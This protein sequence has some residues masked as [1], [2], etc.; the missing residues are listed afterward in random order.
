MTEKWMVMQSFALGVNTSKNSVY[1]SFSD[2][3][4]MNRYWNPY[5][6]NGDPVTYYYHPLNQN[7]IDNPL[8]N[9]RVGCWNDSK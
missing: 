4:Q 3:V 8:Y 5:D 7:P 9:W 2:Y 6:E 1:G